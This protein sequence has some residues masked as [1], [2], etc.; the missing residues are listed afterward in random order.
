MSTAGE[1]EY[2][3]A[4]NVRLDCGRKPQNAR[5]EKQNRAR[6]PVG[7]KSSGRG[8]GNPRDIG[9]KAARSAS[10]FG[11]FVKESEI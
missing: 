6:H 10:P 9:S 1:W 5:A 8:R 3:N 4:A 2:R 7:G 11:P